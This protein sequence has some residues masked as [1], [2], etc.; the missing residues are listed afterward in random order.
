VQVNKTKPETGLPF[1]DDDSLPAG[2]LL[3]VRLKSAVAADSPGASGTFEAV[4][5]DPVVIEGTA[6]VPRG[7]GVEGRIE[8]SRVSNL[9]Q[10]RGYLRLTL[11][12]IDVGGKDLPVQTSS[13]FVRG[14]TPDSSAK[15][16]VI[17]LEKGRRLTFRLAEPV[18]VTGQQA[19]TGR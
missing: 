14:T 12:S 19:L 10:N 8:S 18:Y 6:L 5:E 1:R 2:T 9:K 17:N 15:V 4:M 7:A 13:L 3:T 11:D 16:I